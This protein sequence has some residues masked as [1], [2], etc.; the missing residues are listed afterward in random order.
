MTPLRIATASDARYLPG[1]IGT[2]ASTR[3][4]VPEETPIEVLFLHDGLVEPLQQ[5]LRA[6][7]ARLRGDTSLRFLKIDGEFPGFPDFF[8][9]S[10]MPYARLLLPKLLEGERILYLDSDLLF[11]KSPLPLFL[12]TLSSSGLGAVLDSSMPSLS[13]DPPF[14]ATGSPLE[15]NNPYFNSGLM[16]LD[17]EKIR[18]SRL[19]ERA[20]EILSKF[21]TACKFWDQSALNYAA[22]GSF[23]PLDPDWNRQTHRAV[24]DPVGALDALDRRA[25]NIHFVTKSK[26][27]L[28]WSP[29][30]ADRM[31]R[32]LL[33]LVDPGWRGPEFASRESR[34]RRKL[35]FARWLAPF[36]SLRAALKKS[37]SD[38]RTAKF[39]RQMSLDLAALRRNCAQ[40]RRVLGHWKKEIQG[41]LR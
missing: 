40:C 34:T 24:F 22:N 31:F 19:F 17:L 9:S 15:L 28:A 7:L 21:P 4:A 3:M 16:L 18:R 36:F 11:L 27:W 8:F 35:L 13:F 32:I 30:P 26:P 23:T 29:F 2:L 37:D 25:V 10:K 33:D 5:R 38:R 1:A 20:T 6:A 41:K 12:Q 39:W 14:V